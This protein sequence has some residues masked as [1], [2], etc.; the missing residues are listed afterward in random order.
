ML[1]DQFR[2]DSTG[3]LYGPHADRPESAKDGQTYYETDT[4][5]L[6]RYNAEQRR[7][8]LDV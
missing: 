4:C 8:I 2:C 6:F 7:W 1:T 3:N 5:M